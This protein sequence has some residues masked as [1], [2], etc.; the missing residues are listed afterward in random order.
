M[1]KWLGVSA[2][3][4]VRMWRAGELDGTLAALEIEFKC[5]LV[6]SEPPQ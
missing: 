6:E 5:G 3:E 1:R 2:E 4:A